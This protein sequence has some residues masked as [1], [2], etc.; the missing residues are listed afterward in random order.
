MIRGDLPWRLARAVSACVAVA[1]VALAGCGPQEPSTSLTAVDQIRARGELRV[2]TLNLPTTYYKIA[3]GAGRV[4]AG[5]LELELAK[6]FA[7][8]LAVTLVMVPVLNEQAMRD[9]LAA[10]RA[11]IAAAQIT[12]SEDWKG[13]GVP[14]KPYAAIP[15]LVVYRRDHARP[16]STAMLASAKLSVRAGSPQEAMLET[17][18]QT[19]PHM[20][21]LETAPAWAD[22]L[23]DVD[24]GEADYAI[25]D[26]REFSFSH[27]LYPSVEV[28]F[29]LPQPRPVQ[30]MVRPGASDLVARVDAFFAGLLQSG[31]LIKLQ[32]QETGDSR[33][34]VYMESKEF[35]TLMAERLSQYRPWFQQAGS[36]TGLDWRLLAA[37]SYQESKWNRE[38]TSA[39]DA[40]GIMM[41]MQKTAERLGVKDPYDPQQ[42]IFGGAK[43]LAELHEHMPERIPEPDRTWFTIAAYNC[44]PG[45]VEDA[46]E[47]AARNGKN[48]DSWN[49]VKEQLPL[50]Q[51]QEFNQ[52][53]KH[54]FAR[55]WEPV[56]MVERVQRY[57]TLLEWQPGEGLT[58]QSTRIRQPEQE[59]TR[60]PAD[61]PPA[62]KQP[63]RK[64][65]RTAKAGDQ[66]F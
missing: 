43:Y 23:E 35:Q 1:T 3:N 5:G 52:D 6:R 50:L 51:Q 45:H 25:T 16:T 8:D 7:N 46:R 56:Q 32:E 13:A 61:D 66:L 19:V 58:S 10:G 17:L 55:G 12:D 41:L 42:A 64:G 47:L 54:G 31:Q 48:R 57:L 22:P 34:F 24:S 28:G 27:Q 62:P 26:S 14:A 9:E 18:S 39:D 53:A 33:A 49:D 29:P 20:H 36:E 2:V 4:D 44:G 60:P 15:Q 65:P 40:R 11:D 30:W 37:V 59:V 63:P 38:A 21:W